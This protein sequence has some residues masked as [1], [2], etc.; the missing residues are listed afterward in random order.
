MTIGSFLNVCIYRL[1]RQESIVYPPS[2]CPRCDTKLAARDLVPL[3][4]YLWLKGR[5]RSCGAA[6]HWR[7]PLV[8][9]LTGA[10]FVA[11]YGFFGL[12]VLLLKYLFLACLLIVI[13]FI[14]LEHYLIPDRLNLALL[15]G[16]ILSNA[17][18]REL[19]VASVFWGALIP[20]AA[21]AIL[22]LASRGGMGGGDVKLAG[23]AGVFLGWPGSGVALFLACLLAGA[24]GALLL[25]SGRK[26]RKDPMPFAPFFS[27]GV[28]LGIFWG[29]PLLKWYLNFLDLS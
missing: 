25:I 27:A 3:F 21:L 28:F 10:V 18:A 12:N 20:A 5:C 22:A 19:P 9:L 11:L 2:H 7:Y 13:T 15:A 17:V 4:S 1:P 6:I 16:G 29:E 14:D 8:E 26:K 23:A 24:A